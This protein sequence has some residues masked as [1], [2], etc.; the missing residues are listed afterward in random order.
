LRKVRLNRTWTWIATWGPPIVGGFVFLQVAPDVPFPSPTLLALFALLAITAEHMHIPLPSGGY[1]TFGPAI[2][3]PA[4]VL[5]GPVPAALM[6]VVG[7]AVGDGIIRRRPIA[8]TGFN[9]GQ[10]SLAVLL[11]G[12]AWNRLHGAMLSF[13]Y[14]R[15]A[16]GEPANLLPLL[17][18]LLVYA[19]ATILQISAFHA[20]SLQESFWSLFT[21]GARWRIPAVAILGA[22]GLAVTLA[23]VQGRTPI[24]L[25]PLTVAS[26]VAFLSISR[27]QELQEFS[28]LHGAATGLLGT[29]DLEELLGRL[30]DRV[31]RLT[32]PDMVWITLC[33]PGET[34]KIALQR[35]VPPALGR[36]TP[37]VL[38]HGASGWVLAHRRPLRIADYQR[39]PRRTAESAVIFP[40]ES[41]RSVLIVPLLVGVEPVG[42]ITLTKRSP[43]YFTAYQERIITTLA[44]QAALAVNN[45]RLYEKS[46]QNLARVEALK[47][48]SERINSE[49]DLQA[50]FDLIADWVHEVLKADRCGLY[51]GSSGHELTHTFARGLPGDY[52]RTVSARMRA[53]A[54]PGGLAVRLREPVI[55][56]DAHVDAAANQESARELGYRTIAAFPLLYRADVIGV[57]ALY[58]D[59][60]HPYS[61]SDIALGAAVA[62]QVAIAVQNAQL[63][64]ETA[65]RAHQLGL[66]NR[67]FTRVATSLRPSE[68]LETVV[69]ELHTTLN[70]P[71]VLI[72]L[73][74]GD[75]LR[76]AAYRGYTGV[77]P[78]SPL[79]VGIVGRV[80]RTG[81]AAL[82]TDVS[83]DPDYIAWDP[84]VTQQACAPILSREAVVG[85]INV[86]V[87]E[88][89]LTPADLDLLTTLAGYAAAALEKAR[90]YEQTQQLAT[91]DGLTSLLN[92][93]AFWQAM[94]RELERSM[95]YGVPLSLIMIEIDKF[96]HYNDTYGHLRGD[97]VIRLVARVLQQEHRAQIDVVARYGGDE[98]MILLPHTTK[99]V[100]AEVAE[101]IRRAVSATPLISDLEVASVTLSLGVA[102]YP[103][104][105]KSADALVEATDRSMYSAKERG[106]NAVAMANSS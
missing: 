29:L 33:E 20:A 59:A 37:A 30:A 74:E 18:M 99:A 55:V 1:Q 40:G 82:V 85:V 24:F 60:V 81:Q 88:P 64:Q 34:Y 63:L 42:I 54:G 50:V 61:A 31:E 103:D 73:I 35:G 12:L 52:L 75:Q 14:A 44:A 36:E 104:D 91:T 47:A 17:A 102:G 105:G 95:R 49:Q 46:Q 28:A 80:A 101:R 53:G 96:K 77:K 13:D 27:A 23:T 62:N 68:V 26:L 5:F 90:L 15:L 76:L 10:R 89:T 98:F 84:R 94:E 3:L 87:I 48:I 100:A 72:R 70:Y 57:L 7:V 71:L 106:G 79:T 2:S 92:Y 45:A 51:L 11:S 58:H 22:S 66:L 97:E 78:S 32:H 4:I 19:V 93:R 41:L 16:P 67:T 8:T 69:E 9:I 6:A 65:H 43:G 21:A 39:D 38:P 86:E 25:I 56:T 83:H